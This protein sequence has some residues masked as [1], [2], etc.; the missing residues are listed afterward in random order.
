MYVRNTHEKF[1]REKEKKELYDMTIG[2][3]DVFGFS[4]VTLTILLFNAMDIA[5]NQLWEMFTIKSL[6]SISDECFEKFP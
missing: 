6:I 5:F 2:K 3:S 4:L 1:F